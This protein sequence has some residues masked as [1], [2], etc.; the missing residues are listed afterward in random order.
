MRIRT[1]QRVPIHEWMYLNAAPRR[2]TETA[3][4]QL[5]R[6]TVDGLPDELRTLSRTASPRSWEK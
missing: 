5:L 3:T 2:G 6:G 4:L 1:I